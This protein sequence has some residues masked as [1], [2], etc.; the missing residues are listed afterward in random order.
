M[1][2]ESKDNT[3]KPKKRNK[4]KKNLRVYNQL[5]TSSSTHRTFIDKF[6]IFSG[7]GE[8]KPVIWLVA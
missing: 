2:K 1:I 4:E 6:G 5:K 3:L 8:D 7:L